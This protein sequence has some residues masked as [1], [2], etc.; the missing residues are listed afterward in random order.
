MVKDLAGTGVRA[1]VVGGEPP[2]PHLV[3]VAR[4]AGLPLLPAEAVGP[5]IRGRTGAAKTGAV[6]EAFGEWEEEQKEYRSE[7]EKEV[8]RGG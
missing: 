3:R 2:D 6:E 1:L 4:E 7:R 8:R 5:D